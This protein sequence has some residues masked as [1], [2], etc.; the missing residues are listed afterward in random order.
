MKININNLLFMVAY[1]ILLFKIAFANTT[2]VE[3]V[4][5]RSVSWKFLYF[6]SFSL[7]AIKIICVNQIS[8]RN[9]VNCFLVLILGV[10]AFLYSQYTEIVALVVLFIGMKGIELKKVTKVF[11]FVYGSIMLISLI[12]SIFGIIEMFVVDSKVHGI[13]YSLGNVYPTDFSAGIFFML[14]AYA[15][16]CKKWY[17]FHYL[18][19][20]IVIILTFYFTKAQTSFILSILFLV[21][22]PFVRHINSLDITKSNLKNLLR[23]FSAISFPLLALLSYISVFLLNKGISLL[24]EINIL[25]NYRIGYLSNYLLNY[26]ISL[27]GNSVEMVGAG[28]GTNNEQQYTYLDNGYFYVLILYGLLF[29]LFLFLGFSIVSLKSVNSLL[30]FILILI[31]LNALLE[32][33]FVNYL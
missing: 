33:R 30:H 27:F 5:V 32:P 24:S 16:F 8:T 13:R 7:I 2:F 12:A 18:V 28:W 25:L 10:I 3:Y 29:G 17:L 21:G 14:L 15:F 6:I 1:G 9:I 26:G 20:T 22:F 19:W 31:S 23:I 4:D 11:F